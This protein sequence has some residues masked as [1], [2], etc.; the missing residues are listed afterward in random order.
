MPTKR[1]SQGWYLG[2]TKGYFHHNAPRQSHHQL[3]WVPRENIGRVYKVPTFADIEKYYHLIFTPQTRS[4]LFL[5]AYS[6]G[7]HERYGQG[8]EAVINGH[9]LR[10]EG[11]DEIFRGH[12]L[13]IFDGFEQE[14]GTGSNNKKIVTVDL[15]YRLM[16]DFMRSKYGWVKR[17]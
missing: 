17:L 1:D 13:D 15:G 11:Q 2:H 10:R 4:V 12:I 9:I 3:E 7:T 5:P 6:K 14:N 8:Q 16:T